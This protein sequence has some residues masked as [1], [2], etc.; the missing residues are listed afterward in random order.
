MM[1][2]LYAPSALGLTSPV[3]G[4]AGRMLVDQNGRIL[5]TLAQQQSLQASR[6]PARIDNGRH[7]PLRDFVHAIRRMGEE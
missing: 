7:V 6:A 1:L 4:P 2:F 3:G 5:L